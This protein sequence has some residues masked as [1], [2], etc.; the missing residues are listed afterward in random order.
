VKYKTIHVHLALIKLRSLS[1]CAYICI[2]FVSIVT[3]PISAGPTYTQLGGQRGSATQGS[4]YSH[5]VSTAGTQGI[6]PQWQGGAEGSQGQQSQVQSVQ[7]QAS[8]SVQQ[9]QAQPGQSQEEFSDMLR[10]L[11]QQGTEFSDLSM[12]NTFQE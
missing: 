9:A 4:S 12:F 8:H 3:S 1:L 11:D 2:S 7:G 5:A 6:W 10:M